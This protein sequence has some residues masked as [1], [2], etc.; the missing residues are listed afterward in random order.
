MGLSYRVAFRL[1]VANCYA[2]RVQSLPPAA[3]SFLR[4]A[5][6][7]NTRP[8]GLRIAL[9]G[10]TLALLLLVPYASPQQQGQRVAVPMAA[11]S[12]VTVLLVCG[13]QTTAAAP[14]QAGG[15]WWGRLSDS[16]WCK[17]F[18]PQIL[19]RM[20][21]RFLAFESAYLKLKN[22]SM[23]V[24]QLVF[25]TM[26]ERFLVQKNKLTSLYTL[27]F[28]NVLFYCVAY[29]KEVV[30]RE[31][32]TMYVNI[33]RTSNVRHL[34]LSTTKMV[35]EWTKAVTFIITVV[36][37]LLVMGLEKGLKDY[38]PSPG[39]LF[40]T[41][42]YFFATE[43][44]STQIVG[45]WLDNKKFEPFESMESLYWPSLLL[46]SHLV[47]STLLTLLCASTANVR[48]VLLSSF[49]NLRVKYRELRDDCIKPLQHELAT[50]SPYRS[51]SRSEVRRHDDV[52]AICLS[53]MT[54]A[55]VTPCYHFFHG[56]CL[57]RCLRESS[58]CPI[59]QYH[60]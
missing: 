32:W 60:L 50:L 48:L 49:T 34:A 35:L 47:L 18:L 12:L 4:S 46:G 11:L 27:M 51:A 36:F 21:L 17:E 53:P 26:C 5:Q 28:F 2:R 30:E 15:G 41:G 55:R 29:V 58:K 59:C 31:D 1:Y 37:L 9:T 22:F 56:D 8:R 45:S 38:S 20:K 10:V 19:L 54:S 23:L 13:L 57:R 33:A 7:R 44:F 42:L 43:K 24:N 25:F 3:A 6:A 40:L 14:P 52:C 16:W 39:Y